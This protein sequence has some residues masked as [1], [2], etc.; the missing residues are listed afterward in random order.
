[1]V[2]RERFE[3]QLGELRSDILY[4]GKQVED[5]LLLALKALES[6]DAELAA[7]VYVAD[8]EV[9][10]LRFAT[11]EKCFT[12][13]VTQQPAARDLRSVVT[14]MNMIVDLERMGDQAKG[15]AKVIPRLKERG[16]RL[17]PPELAQMGEIVINMLRQSMLAYQNDSTGLARFVAAQDD[18]VDDL[19]SRVFGN[20]MLQ[21][22][23]DN[24]PDDVKSS[25]EMLRVARELERFGDLATNIAERVIYRVTG[26]FQEI[27]SD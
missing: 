1:M 20:L 8:E 13:I 14:V 15:I 2:M 23:K 24:E 16:E 18:D 21:M 10:R 17:L 25:Y 5:E 6:F 22:A 11:E 4:M 26:Q 27:N 12:I 3:Q 9:N 7:Q 19:F